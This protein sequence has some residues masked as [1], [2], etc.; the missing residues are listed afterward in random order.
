LEAREEL[1]GAVHGLDRQVRP[2][3]VADEERIA[4]EDEPGLLGPGPVENREAA[5]LGPVARR[6]E[7]AES[8]VA[9]HDLLSVLERI[10]L[11]AGYRGRM[12]GDRGPMLE[13]EAPVTRDVVGVGVRL[14]RAHDSHALL[15]RRAQV[16][17]DCVG[18]I[19]DDRLSRLRIADEIRRA[20]EVV[21]DELPE[22]HAFD[23]NTDGG[24][25]S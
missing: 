11:V 4:R 1:A 19:D 14:E 8:H 22:D 5:V 17:P 20:P 3:G 16:L 18:G 24:L 10:V 21:V 7:H 12:N 25:F 2:G 23:R 15:L 9:E 13:R 6:V